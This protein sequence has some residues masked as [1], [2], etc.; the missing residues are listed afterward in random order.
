MATIA[1]LGAGLL[2]R[3]IALS[4][5]K[6]EHQVSLFEKGRL[7][8]T[9]TTGRLAAA[10]V[11]PVAESVIASQHIVSMGEQSLRLWPELLSFLDL[12][13]KFQ[14]D[15]A[16]I[17][18]HR[19][20]MNELS[21]FQRRLKTN[22]DSCQ[23]IDQQALFELEPELHGHFYHG[24]FLPSEGHIDNQALYLE[25]QRKLQ[26]SNVT[27][28]E[29]THVELSDKQITVD[30]Q[31]LDFDCIIDTRGLGAKTNL[32]KQK[33]NLRGVRGEVARVRAPE[34]KLKRPVRLMHPRYPI[35]IVPKANHEYVIGA[36]EI[37]SS[38]NKGPSV[39]STLELLSAAYSVHKGF[40]EAELL[41]IQAGLRPTLADNEPKLFTDQ[42]LLQANGLYRHGFLLAPYVIAQMLEQLKRQGLLVNNFANHVE[43]DAKL[44]SASNGISNHENTN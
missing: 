13:T 18:A 25:L 6:Q 34:V 19:Q 20:D 29:Q 16:V 15:G 38:D 23:S 17:V 3:L 27:L 1:V 30:D 9:E 4:L 32:G 44:I 39:R 31:R 24:L 40:A 41:S 35:Y 14:Q 10:M 42:G 22:H 2:G 7:D 26:D 28:F 12:K 37:E 43:P 5:N 8:S 33:A 11:A 21:H 36:T